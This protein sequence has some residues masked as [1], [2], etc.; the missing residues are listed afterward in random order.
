MTA[1]NAC[2]ARRRYLEGLV[3]LHDE[4]SGV[5]LHALDQLA[6]PDRVR[7]QPPFEGHVVAQR[8]LGDQRTAA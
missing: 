4:V 8:V 5:T 6:V 1:V 7:V 2:A 3:L